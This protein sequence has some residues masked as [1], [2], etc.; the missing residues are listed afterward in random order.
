[1]LDYA[2]DADGE[3]TPR[4]M[5]LNQILLLALSRIRFPGLP[6]C[7]K[8]TLTLKINWINADDGKYWR[9]K[10]VPKIPKIYMKLMIPRYEIT[11]GANTK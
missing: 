2:G 10:N 9:R 5:Q 6:D 7:M 8:K 3:K 4:E 11:K 1:M